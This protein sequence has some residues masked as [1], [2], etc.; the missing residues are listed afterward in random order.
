M[1]I[2]THIPPAL[3]PHNP[4]SGL[5]GARRLVDHFREEQQYEEL[6]ISLGYVCRTYIP[7]LGANTA[8]VSTEGLL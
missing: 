8:N 7:A 2:R 4:K 5:C 1:G 6:Y 3:I